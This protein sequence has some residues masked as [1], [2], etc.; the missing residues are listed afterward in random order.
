MKTTALDEVVTETTKTRM[1]KAMVEVVNM[2]K[3]HD[4]VCYLYQSRG[5]FCEFGASFLYW[6]DWLFKAYPGGRKQLSVKGN[7]LFQ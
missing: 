3:E 5:G 7:E 4:R 6:S 1:E 2:A